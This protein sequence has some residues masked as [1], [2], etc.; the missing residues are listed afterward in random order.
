MI[1]LVERNMILHHGA[2]IRL[3][4]AQLAED[5]VEAAIVQCGAVRPDVRR[6]KDEVIVTDLHVLGLP[7]AVAVVRLGSD[8]AGVAAIPDSRRRR[9]DKRT[10]P[11]RGFHFAAAVPVGILPQDHAAPIVNES[12]AGNVDLRAVAVRNAAVAAGL[13]NVHRRMGNPFRVGP[14]TRA[15]RTKVLPVS[16]RL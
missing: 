10:V 11:D 2:V 14:S 5:A 15:F 7:A 16:R 9:I 12:V 13:G 6:L 3:P 8:E 4:R 1:V